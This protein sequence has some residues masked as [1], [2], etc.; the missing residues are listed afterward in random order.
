MAVGLPRWSTEWEN[1]EPAARRPRAGSK[2]AKFFDC[3]NEIPTSS[4]QL[5]QRAGFDT[6]PFLRTALRKWAKTGWVNRAVDEDGNELWPSRP[7]GP[8]RR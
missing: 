4:H 6:D 5:W 8:D 2:A 1:L 7:L 3:L